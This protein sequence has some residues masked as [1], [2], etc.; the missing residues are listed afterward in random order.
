L[1]DTLSPLLQTIT[2]T[3]ITTASPY[4]V[5]TDCKCSKQIAVILLFAWGCN[6][7]AIVCCCES[8]DGKVLSMDEKRQFWMKT[9]MD[10]SL[11]LLSL[12][13]PS[14]DGAA[15]VASQSSTGTIGFRAAFFWTVESEI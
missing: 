4:K 12:Y 11:A 14:L 7:H 15:A 6:A 5:S 3:P 1:S 9:D 13:E 2:T 10:G 8:A